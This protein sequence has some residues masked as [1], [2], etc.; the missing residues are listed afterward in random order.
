MDIPELLLLLTNGKNIK[1]R[2]EDDVH[3]E[4]PEIRELQDG[5]EWDYSEIE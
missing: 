4:I 5:E 1:L 3:L 2:F